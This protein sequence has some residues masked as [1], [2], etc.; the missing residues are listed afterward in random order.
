MGAMFVVASL[1]IAPST[2]GSYVRLAAAFYLV[3]TCVIVTLIDLEYLIIPDS[4]TWPGVFLGLVASTIFPSLQV[5]HPGFKL[6]SPHSSALIA[7]LFG[8]IVGGG[9]LILVGLIGNVMLRR[10]LKEAG[11]QDAMGWG[12]IK[13]MGL[14][15]AFLGAS[16]VVGAILIGCFSG[17]VAGLFMKLLAKLRN[18]PQPVGLPFGPFLSVGI[19]VEFARPGLTWSVLDMLTSTAR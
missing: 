18:Q 14:A 8:I 5:G 15:G 1:V 10:R 2:A 19:L 3:A 7:S 17:A 12:D 16:S 11:V 4:I 13:W 6:E 9:V